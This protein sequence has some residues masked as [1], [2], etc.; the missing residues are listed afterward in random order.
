VRASGGAGSWLD[1]EW[2]AFVVSLAIISVIAT[3]AAWVPTRRSQRIDPATLLRS[4]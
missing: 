4:I 3:L 1:A 2:P